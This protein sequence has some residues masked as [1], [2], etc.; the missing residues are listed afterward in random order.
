MFIFILTLFFFDLLLL[1]F[2][3]SSSS[4]LLLLIYRRVVVV[5]VVEV[6]VRAVTRR[7]KEVQGRLCFAA[8]PRTRRRRLRMKPIHHSVIPALILSFSMKGIDCAKTRRGC[9]RF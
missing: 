2:F 7:R 8:A 6:A 1:L 4:S 3:S 5:V 9:I